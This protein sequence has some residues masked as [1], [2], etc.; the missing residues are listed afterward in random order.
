MRKQI[1]P[2]DEFDNYQHS[3]RTHSQRTQTNGHQT[4]LISETVYSTVAFSYANAFLRP[5]WILH[6]LPVVLAPFEGRHDILSG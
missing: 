1:M 5:V 4:L 6:V 3:I 2:S